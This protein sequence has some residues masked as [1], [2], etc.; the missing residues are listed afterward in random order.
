MLPL[1]VH[2]RVRKIACD[3]GLMGLAGVCHAKKQYILS[4]KM[5]HVI[6]S[7]WTKTTEEWSVLKLENQ[8]RTSPMCLLC[9]T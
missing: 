3:M 6:Y 8:V 1:R 4:K 2:E 5:E 9:H 7:G